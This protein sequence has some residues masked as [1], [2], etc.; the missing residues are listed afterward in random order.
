MFLLTAAKYI[1]L[2][3]EITKLS[4]LSAMEY[5]VAFITQV[6]GMIVNN[7][8]FILLWFIFF[9]KFPAINGWTF[10]DSASLF[11]LTAT[12]FG[13]V[14]IFGRGAFELAKTIT[15]GELDYYLSFPKNA[16]WHVAISKT[17]IS[18]IGDFL[19]GIMIFLLLGNPTLE[20]FALFS[21][22][23]VVAGLILFNF[24]VITQSIAFYVGNFEEAALTMFEAL[25]GIVLYPQT[26]F[27]G[28][29]KV[30]MFTLIPA[31]FVGTLPVQLVRTF[32]LKLFSI[33]ILYCLISSIIAIFVFNKG[34]K[35]YESGNLINMRV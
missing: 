19:S 21:L 13:L 3:F 30:L 17:E 22:L 35:R 20:R 10:A 15:K 26:A 33:L 23:S 6:V 31:F 29:L 8:S 7:F 27:Y 28:A 32:D 9:K 14:M 12:S 16:L 5:R 11:A 25:L 1:S 4:I 18:A 34:L 2:G 24:I